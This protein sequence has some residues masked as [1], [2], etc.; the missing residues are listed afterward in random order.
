MT[1][2]NILLTTTLSLIAILSISAIPAFEA[3]AEEERTGFLYAEDIKPVMTFTFRDGVEVH[4]FPVYSMTT[5]FV[6]NSGTTFNVQ[7][8][9][10]NAPHLHKALDEYYKYRLMIDS[11]NASPEFNYRYFDVDVDLVKGTEIVTS[12]GYYNC[13]ILSYSAE[14]L[15]SGD[16]ESYT[17]S[18][19]GFAIVDDIEFRCGGLNSNNLVKASLYEDTFTDY[20]TEPLDYTFAEDVR[21]IVTYDFE[22]GQE[23]IEYHAFF[24]DSGFDETSR[25]GPTFTLERTVGNFPLLGKEI[26]NAR[27]LSGIHTS[28]NSDFDVKVQFV[29][30]EKTLRELDYSDCRVTGSE[31]ITQFD[32]EEGFTGKSGFALVQD[33]SFSCGGMQPMNEGYSSLIGDN[34]IWKTSTVTNIQPHHEYNVGLG[35]TALVTFTYKNGIEVLSF[36]IFNQNNVLDKSYS[37]FTLEGIVGDFPMLYKKVDQSL[38]IQNV[39]GSNSV[40]RFDVDVELMYGEESVRGYNYSGCRVTDYDVNSGMNKEENYIKGKFTLENTFDFE[41]S[42]YTPN[43]PIYDALFTSYAKAKTVN[44]TDLRDTQSWGPGF[45]VQ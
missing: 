45:H 28:Y 30:S 13:E 11:P 19:S 38:A 18:N 9:I 39:Q 7:G 26:D 24:L 40:E 36:P 41:C 3:F 42:G 5:D 25:A 44:T 6:S 21:T 15:H 31:I 35:A 2:K 32:K 10:G 17:S 20:A 4:E 22:N 23:R 34:P 14:T 8:V 27:K 43:N 16:Y 1:K 12:L 37:A 33:T 29:N